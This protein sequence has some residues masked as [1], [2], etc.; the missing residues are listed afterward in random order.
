MTKGVKK[1]SNAVVYMMWVGAAQ[2]M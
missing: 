1:N 2:L